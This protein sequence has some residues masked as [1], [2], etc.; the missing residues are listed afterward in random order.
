[1]KDV[2]K[3]KVITLGADKMKLIPRCMDNI[4]KIDAVPVTDGENLEKDETL[5]LHTLRTVL[6]EGTSVVDGGRAININGEFEIS[7]EDDS[8]E[9]LSSK[10]YADKDEAVAAWKTLTKAQYERAKELYEKIE[11]A[12][13]MLKVSLEEEQY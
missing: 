8:D 6:V 5:R 1:M 3:G 4:Y 9:S 12:K 2:R 10:T 11:N 7:L 13:N